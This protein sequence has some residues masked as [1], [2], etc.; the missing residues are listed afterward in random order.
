MFYTFIIF[1]LF[2]VQK[3]CLG[4]ENLKYLEL[5]YAW[6]VVILIGYTYN[7]L[8]FCFCFS[9]GQCFNSSLTSSNLNKGLI[10]LYLL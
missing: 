6:K 3:F 1:G 10:G 8:S 7:F 4:Q 2:G 9:L 5:C